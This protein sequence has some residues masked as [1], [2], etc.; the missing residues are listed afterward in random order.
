MAENS[1]SFVADTLTFVLEPASDV[2]VTLSQ[3]LIAVPSAYGGNRSDMYSPSPA[4]YSSAAVRTELQPTARVWYFISTFVIVESPT[5]C[6]NP[7]N[8]KS[9][10]S[11][12]GL[13]VVPASINTVSTSVILRTQMSSSTNMSLDVISNFTYS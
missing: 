9:R 13:G 11:E 8:R 6:A 1:V 2:H 12:G 10:S 3:Y 7:V 5:G 4:S